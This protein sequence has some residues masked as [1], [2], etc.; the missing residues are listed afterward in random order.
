MEE[1]TA[2]HDGDPLNARDAA[3]VGDGFLDQLCPLL[4]LP[5]GE[6]AS[7]APVTVQALCVGDVGGRL[8][9][10]LPAAA[11][12]RTIARRAV[13]KGFISRVFGAEVAVC[14]RK[15][16][17][18]EIPGQTI[19]IWLGFCESSA[20]DT[21]E[22][23]DEDVTVPFGL[24]PTGEPLVP[25]VDSLAEIWQVQVAQA[26][27][28]PLQTAS[29]GPAPAGF[30][31]RLASL[32]ATVATLAASLSGYPAKAEPSSSAHP[33]L[34][35]RRVPKAAAPKPGTVAD[36]NTGV[37]PGLDKG[38]VAAA[39]AAGVDSQAL[40]EMSRLVG[41]PGPM[42]R[43][44]PEP[45]P[46]LADA[47]RDPLEESEDEAQAANEPQGHLAGAGSGQALTSNGSAE[48]LASALVK[49]L[50]T[51]QSPSSQK[52]GALERALD[53]TG[54]GSLDT[55]LGGGRRNSSARRL[56]R[57]ALTSS[58]HEISAI[59]EN[60]MAEDLSASTPGIAIPPL[61][62]SR[63]WLEHR[64]KVQAF[65]TMV[66]L[67]WAIA[68]ALDCLRNGQTAQAR[69]RLNI[70]LLQADQTS[71]DKGNWLLSQELSLEPSPPM[72]SFR[73]HDTGQSSAEGV[74]SKLLDPRWA[75]IALSRLRDE[76]DFLEK[77]HRLSQRQTP[78]PKDA[79]EPSTEA[80]RRAPGADAPPLAL[81]ALW[82]SLPRI[83]LKSSGPFSS[84]LRS[85]L[86]SGAQFASTPHTWPCPMPF[87]EAFAGRPAPGLWRKSLLNLTVAQLSYL[88]LGCPDDCPS[89]VRLGVPLNR[90]QWKAVRGLRH[91][92]FGSFFPLHYEP[93]DYGR[94]GHKVEGQDKVLQ[95]LGRAAASVCNSLGGY[96]PRS[97]TSVPGP[98]SPAPP[99]DVVGLLP[100]KPDVAALPITAARVKLPA[101]PEFD[102]V[103]YMDST[104]KEFFLEPLRHA[105]IPEPG[106]DKPPFVKI[107]ADSTQKL[108]LLQNLARSGR[109]EPL[110]S[111]PPERLDWGAGLFCVAKSEVKDRLILDARPAN[112]LEDFPG[113]WVHTL[114]SAACL[115]GIVLKEGEVLLMAGTDLVD[116]FYQFCVSPQRATRNLL[117]CALTASEAAFVF[118]RPASDFGPPGAVVHCGLTSLAM[119]D[120]SACEFAQCSHLGVLLQ[121]RALQV[122][123]LMVQAQAPPRG[124]LSVG[125]VID[126][127]IILQRCLAEQLPKFS[128]KPGSS[129]GSRRLRAAL[130]AYDRAHLRYSPEKT[131]EDKTQA[132]FWGVD[133]CGVSGLVRPN[134]S[135]FWPL[136]LITTRVIQ[137][138]LAT[139]SLL[140]SLVGSWVSVFMV[141]RRLLSL[142]NL[143]FQVLREGSPQAILRLSP[144]L[145]AELASFVCLGHLA[146][147]D[148]RAPVL[149][150]IIATDASSTWQ[151]AV[152]AHVAPEVSEE[153]L[154]HTVQRGSWTRLLSP[155]AAY[156]RQRCLLEPSDELPGE[157]S[158][159]AHPLAEA[160]ARVPA[161]KCLWRREYRNRVHINVAELGAYLREE[162]RVAGR[163]VASRPL[164]G[165]DSQVSL[166][167]LCKGRSS[168]G[169]LNRM[170]A[171]SLAPL[172]SSRVFPGH[173]FYPS[174]LNPADDPTRHLSVRPPSCPKPAWWAALEAGDATL[175]EAFLAEHDSAPDSNTGCRAKTV[176]AEGDREAD[177]KQSDLLELGGMRPIVTRSNRESRSCSLSRLPPRA[178][179]TAEPP[180]KAP[181]LP[182]KSNPAASAVAQVL[183]R[184]PARQ[185]VTPPGGALDLD[186]PG[187]LD[188]FD[189][190]LCFARALVRHGAPWVL[191]FN[192]ARSPDED[193]A[194][195]TRRALLEWLLSCKAFKVFR[196]KP[197][198][199][200]FSRAVRPPVRSRAEPAG[201][202][203]LSPAMFR[204]VHADN[205]LNQWLLRCRDLAVQNAAA[206]SVEAPDCAYF[207]LMPGW[208]FES[209]PGSTGTFRA[210]LCQFGCLWRK[211]TRVA[212]NCMLASARLL[213][214]GKVRHLRLLGWSSAHRLP[215]SAVAEH[216]PAGFSE[217]LALG[218]CSHAGWTCA[219]PLDPSACA[220]LGPCCRV[221]EAK[222]PGPRW[223]RGRQPRSSGDLEAQPLQSASSLF[224]G[225]SAWTSFLV[226]VSPFLSVDP[227]GLF[228]SCPVL[229]AMALRAF[230]NHLYCSGG[231]KHTFRYTLVGAQ[232]E[233]PLLKGSLAPA[234][235]L[236]SRW[237]AV[238]P[239]V[240][241]TP[242]P[243]PLLKAMVV[244]CW[245][246]GF[247]RWAACSLLAFYGMA[248]IGE[249]LKC[250]REHLMLPEDL[251]YNVGAVFLRLETSKTSLRGRPKVQHI[252]VD[253]EDAIALIV[254]AFGSLG[255]SEPLFPLSPSAYR[256]RWDKCLKTL[257]LEGL[258]DVTPGGLRGGGAVAAYHR[259]AAIADIQW[260]LRLKHMGT[261]EHYLQEVAALAALDNATDDAKEEKAQDR[262]RKV[263]E[264]PTVRASTRRDNGKLVLNT[265]PNKHSEVLVKNT[266][267]LSEKMDA[268]PASVWLLQTER[269]TRSSTKRFGWSPTKLAKALD[270]PTELVAIAGNLRQAGYQVLCQ[271]GWCYSWSQIQIDFSPWP[272][273]SCSCH[274]CGSQAGLEQAWPHGR[275]GRQHRCHSNV[276]ELVC[277][278]VYSSRM[279]KAQHRQRPGHL[280]ATMGIIFGDGVMPFD[281]HD[282][283]G[284]EVWERKQDAI[285]G[286]VRVQCLS[287]AKALFQQGGQ[288][289]GGVT[290]FPEAVVAD[291]RVGQSPSIGY[292]MTRK[293]GTLTQPG[294]G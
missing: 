6:D 282:T 157:V 147:V 99:A 78:G 33:Q 213:C 90:K 119:G 137:L 61:T 50:D 265:G 4:V 42:G 27:A 115:G 38:V 122:G 187:A 275:G 184:F 172:L 26:Q 107:L 96:L 258:V 204:K 182:F 67:A 127:L 1:E 149:P 32:E 36:A 130:E 180:G 261:L 293:R 81:P 133:C 146:V 283:L 251:F 279:A 224:L 234:W 41:A 246:K 45:R 203:H 62:S 186:V 116:C 209:R 176:P 124:L 144:E 55:S 100:G 23:S 70:A 269:M 18:S 135:R 158:Y 216:Y 93:S 225:T 60:L 271:D 59:I 103:P 247:R 58:P 12:H 143:C 248:R 197:P 145:K 250:R 154:R 201:V 223:R 286:L 56:L 71:V 274:S 74:Y 151:A 193:L 105:R 163:Y 177:F 118:E 131:F 238:E 255:R 208:Q 194:C 268:N 25:L 159:F 111:V 39:L 21:L 228:A 77:R 264:R 162:A 190:D 164:F 288:D 183:A 161:Y 195:S 65:P 138:G 102:P 227:L 2:E 290:F 30:D 125:L 7:G 48:A 34:R 214:T 217:A 13:P 260:K 200:S 132:S 91:L 69:A 240:H 249:V 287:V 169:V 259:G 114:A 152:E 84:F 155:Q 19:R 174:A 239:V 87:P 198:A 46:A 170:L 276:C 181:L 289:V 153:L 252:R 222:H 5:C 267:D 49:C 244:L 171:A 10:A 134:P 294:P 29:E 98:F 278:L 210:D 129:A 292:G 221:G 53:A 285:R 189:S 22:V 226:W 263:K 15:D 82:N 109:L 108:Q 44:K 117:A 79:T 8:L 206:Y 76:A 37:Y 3:A 95:A 68:G 11:W 148:L 212:T 280:C 110:T 167:C 257:G 64:S 173:L 245:L 28:T 218:L 104:T 88:Y 205:L 112:A 20:E 101:R 121:G 232:R 202:G 35:L 72:A 237:E 141:R 54:G 229:A 14:S 73:R 16:R 188:L 192:S 166:G 230:G 128:A 51:F 273:S 47:G 83:L 256:S 24:L 253:D 89:S 160:A 272:S 215:W 86:R 17:V 94:I 281:L 207:W 231:T 92:V 236:L 220:K 52:K 266:Y 57:E 123:E 233:L 178:K 243:E 126:D 191:T 80:G 211:R 40:Q 136:V 156:L 97:F 199:S 31:Q 175:L 120:S 270:F 254:H 63:A 284:W 241:R 277:E 219:R 85:S 113:R 291:G 185:F 75:E 43:L 262:N 235:E 106:V 196:A 242:L 9:I 165:L 66:H 150:I 179:C 142:V 168:S 140:E 139:R